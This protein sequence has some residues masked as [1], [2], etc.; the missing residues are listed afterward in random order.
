MIAQQG[1]D[2]GRVLVGNQAA[3]QLGRGPGRDDGLEAVAGEAAADAVEL[4]R[5]PRPDPLVQAVVRLP[6]GL[7]RAGHRRPFRRDPLRAARQ[8]GALLVVQGADVVVE[9][10]DGHPP[11]GVVQP[12]QKLGQRLD[13]VVDGAAVVAAVQVAARAVDGQL[14]LHDP[15][16]T[17]AQHRLP[18]IREGTVRDDDHIGPQPVGVGGHVAGDVA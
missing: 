18:L 15:A 5:G 9:A 7:R 17:V 11:L 1:V 13:R 14:H 6:P 8:Q 16:Q 4:Q 12:G 10:G 3:A 2:A